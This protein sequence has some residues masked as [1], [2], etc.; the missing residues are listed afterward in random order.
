VQEFQE[1]KEQ[2]SVRE[3][4]E[5]FIAW[6]RLITIHRPESHRLILQ[7]LT[8]SLAR[9]FKRRYLRTPNAER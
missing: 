2:I 1:F 6:S 3:Q 4:I 9:L 7:L 8:A 5:I